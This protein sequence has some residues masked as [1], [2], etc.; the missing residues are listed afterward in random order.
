[1]LYCLQGSLIQTNQNRVYSDFYGIFK[2]GATTCELQFL[3]GFFFNFVTK[4]IQM[5]EKMQK[6]WI[7]S[8]TFYVQLGWSCVLEKKYFL[9]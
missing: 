7:Q 5:R 8:L 9:K 2:R 6:L 3:F 1:M 4:N